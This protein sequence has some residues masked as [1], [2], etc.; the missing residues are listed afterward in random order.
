MQFDKDMNSDQAELFLEVRAFVMKCIDKDESK[1]IEKFTDK[2]TSYYSKEYE[3]G[4]CYIKTMKNHVRIGWFKGA[5]IKDIYNLLTGDGKILRGQTIK[6]FDDVQ[7]KAISYYIE[8][9][10]IFLIESQER[11]FLKCLR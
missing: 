10:K 11:K 4:F 9:T 2:L 5:S 8:E 6:V 3:N 7:K 1:V